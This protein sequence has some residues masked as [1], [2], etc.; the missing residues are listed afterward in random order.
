MSG[1]SMSAC[2]WT[3]KPVCIF[4]CKP[5]VDM[6]CLP[7]SQPSFFL[8]LSLVLA[9][10]DSASLVGP[11]PQGSLFC[12]STTGMTDVFMCLLPC[13]HFS[14]GFWRSSPSPP[15]YVV[16]TL[17]TQRLSSPSFPIRRGASKW[18]Q[19]CIM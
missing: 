7:L 4:A 2:L 9:I 8:D 1:V 3:Q 5:E 13:L 12:F 17:Q 10:T 16:N 14:Q 6:G 19:M 15:A 18:L 11:K